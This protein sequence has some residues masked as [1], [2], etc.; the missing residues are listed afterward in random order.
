MSAYFSISSKGPFASK[1][2]I[3][4]KKGGTEL[5]SVPLNED[6]VATVNL[7]GNAKPWVVVK[8]SSGRITLE[9]RLYPGLNYL[10]PIIA[11]E[12]GL[13]GDAGVWPSLTVEDG[14]TRVNAILRKVGGASTSS[15]IM[16]IAPGFTPATTVPLSVH[17]DGSSYVEGSVLPIGKVSIDPATWTSARVSGFWN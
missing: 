10:H 2:V 13:E 12:E 14:I 15:T 17:L 1:A 16:H 8:D 6:T 3:Y 7:E 9:A 4:D 5:A 11:L